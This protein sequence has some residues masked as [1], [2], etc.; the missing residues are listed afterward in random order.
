MQPTCKGKL[1]NFAVFFFL[2]RRRGVL[3]EFKYTKIV[4]RK[5]KFKKIETLNSCCTFYC[6]LFVQQ[7]LKTRISLHCNAAIH[8]KRTAVNFM[9]LIWRKGHLHFLL[10]SFPRT[11]NAFHQILRIHYVL[12]RQRWTKQ[13][14][15][16]YKIPRVHKNPTK[17]SRPRPTTNYFA[18]T[19]L[20]HNS[21]RHD[22]K[23]I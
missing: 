23:A 1:E 7:L 2:L 17:I 6:L 9:H 5:K 14:I 11:V 12:A 10:S 20:S 18:L 21:S 8:V 4:I 3:Q 15:P 13:D 19:R 22:I 16:F